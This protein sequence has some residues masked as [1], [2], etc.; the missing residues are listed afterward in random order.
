MTATNSF[1]TKTSLSG[2]FTTRQN[3]AGSL[4]CHGDLTIKD[5]VVIDK[6]HK[7]MPRSS[8]ADLWITF[9]EGKKL[10]DEVMQ[11]DVT[12]LLSLNNKRDLTSTFSEATSNNV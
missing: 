10:G 1:T 2:K 9:Y 7:G 4:S 3:S 6:S 5:G 11:N 12:Y 8:G